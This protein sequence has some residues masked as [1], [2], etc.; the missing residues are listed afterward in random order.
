MT[1]VALVFLTTYSK[2]AFPSASVVTALLINA[3]EGMLCTPMEPQLPVV[4][5]TDID[6]SGMGIWVV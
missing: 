1:A 3:S 2:Y 6:L 4:A 5:V